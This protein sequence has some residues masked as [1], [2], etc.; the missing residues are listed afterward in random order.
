VLADWQRLMWLPG[1]RQHAWEHIQQL[2]T[3]HQLPALDAAQFLTTAAGRLAS[4]G[5]LDLQEQTLLIQVPPKL[6]NLD[7]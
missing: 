3:T 7:F 6:H 2:F 5:L 1:Q 4:G